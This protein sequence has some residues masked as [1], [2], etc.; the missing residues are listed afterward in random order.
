MMDD[1]NKEEHSQHYKHLSAHRHITT[2]RAFVAHPRDN[3]VI[4]ER[5]SHRL[6]KLIAI[7]RCVDEDFVTVLAPISSKNLCSH[8]IPQ[9]ITTRC[10]L[11]GP[12]SYEPSVRDQRRERRIPKRALRFP[13]DKGLEVIDP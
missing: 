3:E 1:E 9:R 4:I 10:T 7:C 2:W 5:K 13:N 12:R 8:R 11:L 6:T